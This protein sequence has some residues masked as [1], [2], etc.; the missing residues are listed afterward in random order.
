MF[1]KIW[2]K[3]LTGEENL[4]C[5]FA[6]IL[7]FLISLFGGVSGKEWGEGECAKTLLI[8]GEFKPVFIYFKLLHNGSGTL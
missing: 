4:G 2:E 5:D 7:R 8:V 3:I 1:E 6:K